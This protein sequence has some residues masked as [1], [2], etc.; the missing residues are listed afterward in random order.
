MRAAG[1]TFCCLLFAFD[2]TSIYAFVT[3]YMG[4]FC[5]WNAQCWHW[6]FLGCP[7]YRQDLLCLFLFTQEIVELPHFCPFA[8]LY[9]LVNLCKNLN[10]WKCR[11]MLV[12]WYVYCEKIVYVKCANRFRGWRTEEEVDGLFFYWSSIRDSRCLRVIVFCCWHCI[13]KFLYVWIVL[14]CQHINI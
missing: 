6:F 13:L 10:Q 3:P 12:R 8:S 9:L 2:M 5:W 7:I 4:C 14:W 11:R 1:G